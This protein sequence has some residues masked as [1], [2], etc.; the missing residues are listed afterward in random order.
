MNIVDYLIFK[1]FL[2]PIVIIIFVIIGWW[3]NSIRLKIKYKK[4]EKYK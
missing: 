1:D 3:V 4:K 2:F